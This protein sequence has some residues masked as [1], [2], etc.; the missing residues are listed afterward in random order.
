MWYYDRLPPSAR[1]ALADANFNWSA[2]AVLNKWKRGISGYKT[3]KDIA[4]SIRQADRMVKPP[5]RN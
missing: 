3:G 1:A 2:G 5:W 4:A